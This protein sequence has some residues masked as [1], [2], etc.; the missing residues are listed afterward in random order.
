MDIKPIKTE[1][2]YEAVL[3]EIERLFDAEPDTPKGDRL[4]VLMILVEAYES[5]HYDILPPDPIEAIKY[6]MESRGLS[7]KDLEPYIGTRARVS[8]ILNRQRSLSLRMIRRLEAGLGIPAEILI[9]PYQLAKT[10]KATHKS[11]TVFEDWEDGQE[12]IPELDT[13]VEQVQLVRSLVEN[14]RLSFESI[15]GTLVTSSE[16][17]VSPV[18]HPP[19][20]LRPAE[21]VGKVVS[22]DLMWPSRTNVHTVGRNVIDFQSYRDQASQDIFQ[23]ESVQ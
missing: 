4:E 17:R 23:K 15:A 18:G 20:V 12:Q 2:D 9:Q 14:I 21:P 7:R 6:H 5:Q 10:T 22:A 13:I 8:E 16:I 1:A 3:G 11:L 19:A